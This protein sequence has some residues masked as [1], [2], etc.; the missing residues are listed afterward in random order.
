ML[1]REIRERDFAGCEKLVS[2]FVRT[3]RP[4]C[5][6]D[7]V[8]RFETAPGPQLQV[9]WVE[10]KRERLSAFVATLGFSR[11]VLSFVA[12]QDELDAFSRA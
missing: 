4:V 1:A 6:E 11:G 3:L 8:V 12:S 7:P 2:H 9:D 5:R 10:F